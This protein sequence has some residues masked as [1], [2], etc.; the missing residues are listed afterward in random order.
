MIILEC[1]ECGG[2]LDISDKGINRDV[3][4]R[5]CGFTSN[6]SHINNKRKQNASSP[7]IFIKRK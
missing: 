6:L 2:E 5:N 1:L 7:E 4:C 3:K